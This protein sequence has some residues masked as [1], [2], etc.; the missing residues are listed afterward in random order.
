[1]AIAALFMGLTV[2][3]I[4]G[5]FKEYFDAFDAGTLAAVSAL[6]EDYLAGGVEY[7]EKL[8]ERGKL[9]RKAMQYG[10]AFFE[11]SGDLIP[12]RFVLKRPTYRQRIDALEQELEKKRNGSSAE[13]IPTPKES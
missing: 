7:Y 3:F 6:G 10:D 8:A 1:M 2:L 11:E 9:M 13:T 4:A 12:F 5:M